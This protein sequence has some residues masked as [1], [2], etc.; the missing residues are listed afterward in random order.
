MAVEIGHLYNTAVIAVEYSG[1]EGI[2]AGNLLR[3]AEYPAI[4]QE[5]QGN[6]SYLHWL[7]TEKNREALEAATLVSD[8][9]A[10]VTRSGLSR[11]EIA[12]QARH[13]AANV[14]LGAVG[15]QRGATQGG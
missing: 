12:A 8:H 11:D 13:I 9:P 1:A 5:K 2:E 15:R 4:Y 6:V 7:T 3:E 10:Q 14:V